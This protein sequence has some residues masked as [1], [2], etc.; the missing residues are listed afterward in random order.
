[1]HS[2]VIPALAILVVLA[3][4][5][6]LARAWRAHAPPSVEQSTLELNALKDRL[7]RE[8][9]MTAPQAGTADPDSVE[10]RAQRE[11][12]RLQSQLDQTPYAAPGA[13]VRLRSGSS[14]SRE[15]Y[16]RPRRGTREAP[17]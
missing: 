3:G 15:E 10:A 4:A 2:T 6:L 7:M 1:L 13:D 11:I 16:E 5:I 9:N 8:R 14:I 17:P 12:R